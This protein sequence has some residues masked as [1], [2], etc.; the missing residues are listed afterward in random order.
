MHPWLSHHSLHN[1]TP[2]IKGWYI[3]NILTCAGKNTNLP[4]GGAGGDPQNER[5][6][7]ADEVLKYVI[8]RRP[9]QNFMA[10]YILTGRRR[11][12][13]PKALPVFLPLKSR[14]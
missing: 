11:I 8:L 2:V 4:V 7:D 12:S 6:Q 5:L 13:V 3:P 10:L 1:D 14:N 9:T